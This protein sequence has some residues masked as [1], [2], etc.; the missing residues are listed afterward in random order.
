MRIETTVEISKPPSEVYEFLMDEENLALW[1]KNFIKLE[2]LEGLGGEIGSTARH[3]YNEKGKHIAF[4]EEIKV[5][6]APKLFESELRNE[7]MS[8]AIS[9]RLTPIGEDHTHLKVISDWTPKN[10]LH[11]FKLLFTKKKRVKRQEEDI[12]RLK[13]AIEALGVDFE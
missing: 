12:Q 1:I 13:E 5:I 4:I 9:K 10:L 7:N 2:R 11:Q 3:I 8:I 6:E